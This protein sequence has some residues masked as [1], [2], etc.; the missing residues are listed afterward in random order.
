MSKGEIAIGR[1]R[2]IES[3]VVIDIGGTHVRCGGAQSG[4]VLADVRQFSTDIF[5][6]DNPVSTLE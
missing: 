4:I 6:I 1:S 5:Q 2:L 3:V